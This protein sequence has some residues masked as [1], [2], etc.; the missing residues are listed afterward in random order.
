MGISHSPLPRSSVQSWDAA[1]PC[2][3]WNTCPSESLMARSGLRSSGVRGRSLSSGSAP[4]CPVQGA[5]VTTVELLR[6]P[7]QVRC[8]SGLTSLHSCWGKKIMRFCWNPVFFYQL[9]RKSG[10]WQMAPLSV[11]G[12]WRWTFLDDGERS[13]P[14]TGVWP[15]PMLSVVSSAVE[16][17]SPPLEDHTWWAEMT[18]S[19]QSDFTVWG[20][21]LSCGVALWLPW[22][23][24]TVLM[25]TRPLWSAQV[26]EMEG[27][28]ILRRLLEWYVS[29]SREGGKIDFKS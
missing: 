11:R 8:G 22:V 27:L 26:R 18:R 23:V 3:S 2:L 20:L 19:Q 25:A 29:K 4:E 28:L 17:P 14:P 1:R 10:S 9:T 24:P 13:V 7:V 21:S 15:M 12:R 6:L 16:S 5:R